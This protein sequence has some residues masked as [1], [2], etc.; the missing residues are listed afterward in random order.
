MDKTVKFRLSGTELDM[1]SK[2][3]RTQP[4]SAALRALIRDEYEKR[5]G[6]PD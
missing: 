1:L 5:F 6:L 2:I 3:A 4:L